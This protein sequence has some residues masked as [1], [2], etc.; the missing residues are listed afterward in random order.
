MLQHGY[1]PQN[2]HFIYQH[3]KPMNFYFYIQYVYCHTFISRKGIDMLFSISSENKSEINF[4]GIKVKF[5]SIGFHNGII[6]GM[7]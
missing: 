6:S 1:S 3:V 7:K 4:L 5:S 2:Y